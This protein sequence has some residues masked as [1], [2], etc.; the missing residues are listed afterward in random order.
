MPQTT[1]PPPPDKKGTLA[2]LA[3]SFMPGSH[4]FIGFRVIKHPRYIY[5]GER[6]RDAM[7]WTPAQ[8]Y[9]T[10]D[11]P[12]PPPRMVQQEHKCP[13]CL[14]LASHP[15]RMCVIRRADFR[16]SLILF[17]RC[18]D[19]FYCFLC[20]RTHFNGTFEC[21]NTTCKKFVTQH[22]VPRREDWVD[23]AI[24]S[25]YAAAYPGWVDASRVDY[26]FAGI[27]FPFHDQHHD[28]EKWTIF[29]TTG[30]RTWR[31]PHRVVGS[32]LILDALLR[33]DPLLGDR[34]AHTA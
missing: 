3:S 26:S 13:L 4:L 22:W 14:S 34:R 8:A 5:H 29:L 2:D 6:T 19:T 7:V 11:R 24:A 32:K 18:C 20:L 9:L 17:R 30:E 28:D 25:A 1:E 16:S 33:R 10:A 15:M 21:P 27:I 31:E 12:P 23:D